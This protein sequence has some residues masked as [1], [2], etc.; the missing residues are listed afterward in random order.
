MRRWPLV[1]NAILLFLL[2]A[3]VLWSVSVTAAGGGRLTP[4]AAALREAVAPVQG[5]LYRVS[6]QVYQVFAYPLQLVQATRQNRQLEQQ[7]AN[8]RAQVYSLEEYRSEAQ[9]LE[10]I[11]NYHP[12]YASSYGKLVAGVTGRN[13]GNWFRTLTINRGSRAGVAPNLPVVTPDGLV[14]RVLDVT[15]DTAEVLLI[16][17]P[18]SGVGS[19]IMET[20]VPGIVAGG[21][22][23]TGEISLTNIPIIQDVQPGQTVVTSGTGSYFPQGIPIGVVAK[24]A[25]E[26]AGL[27]KTA[28]LNPFADLNRLEEVI[29]LVPR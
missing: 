20:R 14:G 27:F 24:V 15:P 3:V 28:T 7:V 6:D 21:S 4:L 22:S 17:D 16:T 23:G 10:T 26:P 1:R 18:R 29:V 5:G 12:V 9:R 19:M 11:L 2:V 13:A 25:N 8:L